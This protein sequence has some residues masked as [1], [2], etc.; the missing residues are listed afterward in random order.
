MVIHCNY[1][2]QYFLLCNKAAAE[3]TENAGAF[4]FHKA[5]VCNESVS[6]LSPAI[7]SYSW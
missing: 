5:E 6:E 4:N 7:N 2:Q 3:S 1:N